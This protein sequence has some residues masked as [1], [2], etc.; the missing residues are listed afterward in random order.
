MSRF[1][2]A[3][4]LP[5]QV[6][7]AT[8]RDRAAVAR[9]AAGYARGTAPVVTGAFR[10]GIKVLVNSGT[11]AVDLI[12]D[13]PLSIIKEY[14]TLD[15]PAHMTLTNAARRYGRLAGTAV[16]AGGKEGHVGARGSQAGLVW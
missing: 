2:P 10:N 7:K 14:G 5:Q 15:T 9:L 12:D 4:D 11:G 13:D 3:R 16:V 8:T 1:E 6:V